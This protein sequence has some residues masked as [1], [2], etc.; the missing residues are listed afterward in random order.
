VEVRRG[1]LQTEL[2]SVTAELK[3]LDSDEQASRLRAEKAVLVEQLSETARRW[4]T[5]TVAR[6]LLDKAQRKYEEE[7]QPDVLRNAQEFFSTVTGGRYD[8]LISPLGSQVITAVAPDGSS[9][10]T[11]QLSRGTEDQL[12]LALRFGLIRAFGARSAHLPVIVDDI[13]VNFDP[14]RAQRAAAAFVELA[15]TNQVL[16]FTCHPETVDHFRNASKALHV[17]DLSEAPNLK[18]TPLGREG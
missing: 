15:Q 5:L 16:V 10:A 6:T 1:D 18:T 17:I 2:G 11:N 4:A 12:Y 3:R 8:R 7:R 14:E 13:L 9:K